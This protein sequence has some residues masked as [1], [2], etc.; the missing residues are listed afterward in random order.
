MAVKMSPHK[1]ESICRRSVLPS[2]L[3]LCQIVVTL[4]AV[5]RTV[6][7]SRVYGDSGRL[8]RMEVAD[9]LVRLEGIEP[10]TLGLEVRRSIQLSYGRAASLRYT[11][12]AAIRNRRE[13]LAGRDTLRG[14]CASR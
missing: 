9:F 5:R 10:P 8:Y 4:G 13:R 3:D 2:E 12:R 7:F 14:R 1:S 6:T 11:E